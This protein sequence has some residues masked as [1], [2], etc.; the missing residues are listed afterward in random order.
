[1]LDHWKSKAK[2][3]KREVHAMYLASRDP[4][5]PWLARVVGICVVGYAL[6]PIDLIPDPI[7]VIGY[8]DDLLIVPAGLMLFRR[9][10][11]VEVLAECR[12]K[13][14][15]AQGKP[16]SWIAATVIVTIWLITGIGLGMFLYAHFEN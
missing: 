12:V 15:T 8:L 9:M 5:T 13:A 11:P 14:E 4:R 3:L 6:S 10:I 1:M 7:P 16:G 2:G